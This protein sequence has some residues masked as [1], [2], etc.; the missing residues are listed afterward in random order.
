M[1][2][3]SK[4]NQMLTGIDQLGGMVVVLDRIA[5]CETL[6]SI[7]ASLGVS[8]HVLGSALHKDPHLHIALRLARESAAEAMA[9][10][11]LEIAD[12]ATNATERAAR[13]QINARLW[14]AARYHPAAFGRQARRRQ[15]DSR[16]PDLALLRSSEGS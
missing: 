15:G 13:H 3:Q 14:L 12:R 4:K 9:E 7:A 8:R 2:R 5:G 1:K 10:E 16:P 11:A 6:T